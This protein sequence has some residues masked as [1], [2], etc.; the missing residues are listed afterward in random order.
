[1]VDMYKAKS[2]VAERLTE[3]EATNTTSQ[4]VMLD[5]LRPRRRRA[6]YFANP[7]CG[8]SALTILL[9]LFVGQRLN[10]I[11]YLQSVV[12]NQLYQSRKAMTNASSIGQM[13]IGGLNG[14]N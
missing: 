6:F 5:A 11:C 1:M 9:C 2:K 10:A 4:P 8:A 7:N 14:H 12:F 13:S 3:T